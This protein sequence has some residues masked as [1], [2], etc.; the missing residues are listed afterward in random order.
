[1]WET[2]AAA[3]QHREPS[4]ALRELRL[5]SSSPWK[6]AGEFGGNGGDEM[7][8]TENEW[9]RRRRSVGGSWARGDAWRS[10]EEEDAVRDPPEDRQ[11]FP[12]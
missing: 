3:L 7:Y 11:L 4:A 1:V 9:R 12:I 10:L 6:G 8:G 2:T 5:T